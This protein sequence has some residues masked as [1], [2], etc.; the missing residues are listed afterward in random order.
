MGKKKMKRKKGIELVVRGFDN[1][2][3]S[4]QSE[5]RD[6]F[7]DFFASV[8]SGNPDISLIDKA[9][10][11]DH[12]FLNEIDDVISG[13]IYTSKPISKFVA[14]EHLDR[15]SDAEEH[16][17]EEIPTYYY[18]GDEEYEESKNDKLEE[19]D[20]DVNDSDFVAI[21]PIDFSSITRILNISSFHK[22][23]SSIDFNNEFSWMEDPSD[24]SEDDA[25]DIFHMFQKAFMAMLPPI[26]V[27]EASD[28]EKYFIDDSG[29]V[30][31]NMRVRMMR[32]L[33]KTYYGIQIFDM[34][35]LY[36]NLMDFHKFIFDNHIVIHALYTIIS[37][38]LNEDI[39]II[40]GKS[41]DFQ[42]IRDC[43]FY[44]N[45][46]GDLNHDIMEHVLNYLDD[47]GE[48]IHSEEKDTLSPRDDYFTALVEKRMIVLDDQAKDII[49]GFYKRI[50][51][52]MEETGP[53]EES[54]EEEEIADGENGVSA[55]ADAED[56]N[57]NPENEEKSY[58]EEEPEENSGSSNENE[59]RQEMIAR[60]KNL[61]DSRLSQK[62]VEPEDIDP[63]SLLNNDD[64]HDGYS[65]LKDAL[66]SS[67]YDMNEIPDDDMSM[68]PHRK[69]V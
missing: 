13:G 28:Y 40:S 43:D 67:G 25:R 2:R 27:V 41:F 6:M 66:R 38:M 23:L 33:D 24:F 35:Q 58:H 62:V 5:L 1:L 61:V 12:D 16:D 47:H 54:D 17:E 3:A 68:E 10:E 11:P 30:T 31:D 59:T 69:K 7:D 20:D 14:S 52:L 57:E 18:N 26:C 49:C 51:E 39:D 50:N 4:D 34:K 55:V 22:N 53:G 63:S 45:K 8:K 64:E 9:E 32:V 56:Q 15:D 46:I 21:N 60:V 37:V 42:P 44:I 36:S 19:D 48:V 65:T 29:K